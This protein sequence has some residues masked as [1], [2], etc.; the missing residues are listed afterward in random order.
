MTK[1]C[2]HCGRAFESVR[3]KRKFC[4]YKCSDLNRNPPVEQ[5]FWSKVDKRGPVP[6][7]RQELGPCWL[8]T[9]GGNRRPGSNENGYGAFWLKELRQ[10]ISAHR[11][12]W[13]LAH[14]DPGEMLV[15][16]KCDNPR[17]V[18]PEHLFIGTQQ[19]NIDDKVQKSRQAKGSRIG[20]TKV[21]EEQVREIRRLRRDGLTQRE[22]GERFGI[23]QCQVS[24]IVRGVVWK[25]VAA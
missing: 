3:N 13:I 21:T 17:C 5:R 14:A 8:W 19:D 11:M 18:R 1:V 12:S 22:I 2:E 15:L 10:N 25:D 16:H 24:A 20:R 23:A 4:C 6:A 9:A 7:H